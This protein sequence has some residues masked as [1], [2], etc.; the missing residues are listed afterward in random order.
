MFRGATELDLTSLKDLEREA[1]L[2]GLSHVFPPER[3]PFP[4]DDVL[5]RWR[6]VMDDP[7]TEIVV[8]DDE[9]GHGL[10]AYAAYDDSTLRHLAVRPDHW[11]EG[12]ATRAIEVALDAMMLRGCTKASL[13]C[14]R[15]NHRASRLYR[16]LGWRATNDVR[17]APWP[18]HPP[19]VR[20]TRRIVVRE[21]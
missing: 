8:A 13:W 12:L 9:T 20:Y 4:D 11:G 17:E 1:N 5:A 14:L 18:P 7:S 2:A 10:I 3:H 6:I 21:G 19:E 15:E 16:H